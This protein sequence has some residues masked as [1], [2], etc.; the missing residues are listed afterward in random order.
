MERSTTTVKKRSTHY[1]TGYLENEFYKLTYYKDTRKGLENFCKLNN[2]TGFSGDESLEPGTFRAI[3][4]TNHAPSMFITWALQS[5]R[6]FSCK[7]EEIGGKGEPIKVLHVKGEKYLIKTVTIQKKCEHCGRTFA[8]THDCNIRRR[9]FYHHAV[10]AD[11][12]TWWQPIKFVPLGCHPDTKRLF[13][14]YDIETYTYHSGYGKQLIPYLLVLCFKGDRTLRKMA[15]ET[16]VECGFTKY[17]HCFMLLDKT[18]DIVGHKF[19]QLRLDIQRKTARQTWTEYRMRHNIA[20]PR[21]SFLE[22]QIKEEEK[23]LNFW[24]EPCFTEIIVIGH[25]ITGF[26]EIVLA[27][28]V[29]EGLQKEEEFCMFKITRNFMPRAGKLLFND[30]SMVLPNPCYE[31][32][33]TERTFDRWRQGKLE[34][35]DLRWQG[36]KFMVRDTFLLTHCSLRNAA[37]AY[38]LEVSKGYCPYEAV[39]Q[40]F[41]TGT[42]LCD[43]QKY[44]NR[45]YWGNDREFAEN[46][47]RPG[48]TYDI[49]QK[50]IDY[51]VDDVKVTVGLV[52]KLVEGYQKFCDEVLK[53]DCCF[54]IFQ[55]PT[56]SSTT[57]AMFKQMFY[58]TE[59]HVGKFLGPLEAPSE[60]MYEHIRQSVRG[61]RCY[62]SVLGVYRQ[63]IYV[64]DICGMYAS[65]LSHP[66]PYGRTLGPFDAAIAMRHFQA[67]LDTQKKI[68]YFEPTINPMI[69]TVDCFPP[70]ILRLD[71]LPP[72]CSRKSGRLCW[73]NE[74]LLG[75]VL[76]TVDIITLH[77]RGW[78]IKII[79]NADVYAVWTE[80]KPLCR[81][82]VSVNIAAKEKA[83]LEKNQTQR[84][85]SKLLSNA[86]YGSFATR[87][88]NKQIVFMDDMSK[89]VEE[90]LRVGKDSIVSMTSLSSRSL[91]QSNITNWEKYFNLPQTGGATTSR[92]NDEKKNGAFIGGATA[93]TAEEDHVTL[94][95]ITFLSAECNN[96]LLATVQ[97]NSEW[98]K[99]DRYATQIASFV[100]A[101]S[102]AFMSEWATILFEEDWGKPYEEREVKSVYG[103]TDSLF[104]T[105]RGHELM[106]TKGLHRLKSSG[107]SLIYQ[108]GKSL[109]WLVECETSC[110]KCHHPAH[111]SES[112]Y[113]APKLYALKDTVCDSCGNV[114]DGK[115]RA[116]GHAKTSISYALMKQCFL[117]HYLLGR[118]TE[119]YQSERTSLK[120][121][122]TN[123]TGSSAPFTV[124]EKQLRRILR[125][126]ADMTMV[127]GKILDQGFLLFPYDQKQ[128]NPRPQETLQENPFWEDT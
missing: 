27:S 77:N 124:V 14:I 10:M 73:T 80:W 107:N 2:L 21:P 51:C 29:L 110:P 16:A 104:L 121:T 109:A 76:T 13:L 68:S 72:L 105:R 40:F 55:R 8:Y 57:H 11:T 128:P 97:S 115:L 3:P 111:A 118:P 116:K 49:V 90:R 48:E 96:L 93:E 63:P 117:D 19:K 42:Y 69:I 37:T 82:Y 36:V 88:D 112:C 35:S 50:A 34:T 100:L 71:V 53:L 41:M 9:E 43:D 120:R 66:M 75:E 70:D 126:W 81:D 23:H 98:V 103:D 113:L 47:P 20:D 87:L 79:Q 91:P 25:N 12:K 30:V 44:P 74:A 54:N 83:D 114:S 119:I 123:A 122:L 28:H 26:D 31:K 64:Y 6:H 1:I 108:G 89:T 7:V 61:G 4:D 84:S 45:Q 38:Q 62:P 106:Q 59:P 60:V 22:L 78:R 46:K 18:P 58:K 92:V 56:I 32:K 39:N 65:A 33:L 5:D 95:H 101:W 127:Q 99:N 24:A 17:R 125:P 15:E 94:K 86:L 67:L 52:R 102:R 85:I